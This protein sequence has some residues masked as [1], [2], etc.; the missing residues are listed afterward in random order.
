MSPTDL[1]RAALDY[2]ERLGFAAAHRGEIPTI[3]IGRRVLVP[4]VAF[5]K[6]LANCTLGEA[7]VETTQENRRPTTTRRPQ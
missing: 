7:D 1:A 4:K 3:R 2:P 5:E 6:M